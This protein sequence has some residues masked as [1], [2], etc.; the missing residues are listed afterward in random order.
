LTNRLEPSGA[1]VPHKVKAKKKAVVDEADARELDTTSAF[2]KGDHVKHPEYG[3]GVVDKVTTLSLDVKFSRKGTLRFP[4]T[5][6]DAI[7]F[8]PKRTFA[9]KEVILHPTFGAGIVLSATFD[10]IEVEFGVLGKKTM[11]HA[12][13]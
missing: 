1:A 13:A 2:A 8:D 5:P 9:P 4:R 10:R 6:A 3:V 7:P 11:V 12:R